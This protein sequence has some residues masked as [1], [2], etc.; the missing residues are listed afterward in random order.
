MYTT[1]C[2]SS[3]NGKSKMDHFKFNY[4]SC[5]HYNDINGM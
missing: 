2:M 3:T 1:P 5:L 4:G